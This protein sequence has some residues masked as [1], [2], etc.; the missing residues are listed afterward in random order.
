[1]GTEIAHNTMT[2]DSMRLL[3]GK[4]CTIVDGVRSMV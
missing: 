4:E 3:L 2:I 1:M